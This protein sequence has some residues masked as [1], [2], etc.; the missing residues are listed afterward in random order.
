MDD[1]LVRNASSA[2]SRLMELRAGENL[3]VVTDRDTMPVSD[4]FRVAGEQI[5]ARVAVYILP[6][7]QRPLHTVPEDLAELIPD[8]DVAVTAFAGLAA[9]TPFRIDLIRSLTRVTRRLGHAPGITE[10]MLRS[11][12]MS[13]DYDTMALKAHDLIRRFTGA[14]RV[15]VTAPSGTDISMSIA[16]RPFSTDTVIQDGGWGNL[17]AGEIWCAPVEDSADGVIV[18]DGSIGD[19]GPVPHPVR[20]LVEHGAIVSIECRD[21]DFRKRIEDA[22]ALDDGAKRIGELGIGLN[23]GARI[24]GNLLEDEKA[25]RTAHI[26]F[27][28]N[29]NMGGGRNRSRTHRDFLFHEPTMIVDFDDGRFEK[30]IVAGEVAAEPIRRAA[31]EPHRYHRVLVAVDFSESSVEALRVADAVAGRNGSELLVCHVIPRAAAVSPLFPH[32]VAMPDQGMV[33]QE[34]EAAVERLD[35]L[36]REHTRRGPNDYSVL[37]SHGDPAPSIRDLAEQRGVD[38]IVIAI[39]G[40]SSSISQVLLGSVAASLAHHAHCHVLLVRQA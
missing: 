8:I 26:A 37:V 36:V 28:N 23:P 25:F 5:G 31:G 20:M 33:R 12:P 35:D 2:L 6:G 30:V 3:L 39:K 1:L 17:P 11:G 24:T 9:E 40:G 18:C 38:L 15:R 21:Q 34:E 27:G 10:D 19:L 32:Y 14:L 22:I 16:D 7:D 29:E 4:A 13:V